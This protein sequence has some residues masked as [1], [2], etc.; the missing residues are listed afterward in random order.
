MG[1][2]AYHWPLNP[3][4]CKLQ[5]SVLFLRISQYKQKQLNLA[6]FVLQHKYLKKIDLVVSNIL[7]LILGHI[8]YHKKCKY[9]QVRYKYIWFA[10]L[11][12]SWIFGLGLINVL[13]NFISI[14]IPPNPEIEITIPFRKKCENPNTW[15]NYFNVSPNAEQRIKILVFKYFMLLVRIWFNVICFNIYYIYVGIF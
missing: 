6:C 11:L 8:S 9:V 7:S 5:I 13:G 4:H 15:N 3:V 12:V 2:H 14:N 1:Q 10:T